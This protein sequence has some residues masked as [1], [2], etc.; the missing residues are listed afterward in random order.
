MSRKTP[1]NLTPRSAAARQS[2]GLSSL[3]RQIYKKVARQ[4]YE[5]TLMAVGEANTGKTTLLKALFEPDAEPT[6]GEMLPPPPKTVLVVPRQVSIEEHGVSFKLNIIDTPGFGDGVNNAGC[7]EQIVEYI[8]TT[9]VDYLRDE[10]SANRNELVD[11]RV[12]CLLY[13]INPSRHSLKTLDIETLKRVHRKVNVVPVI[14]KADTLTKQELSRLKAQIK[15]DLERE[16]IQIFWPGAEVIGP[17]VV[18]EVDGE[19]KRGRR[20][21]WG[22]VDIDNEVHCDFEKLRQM[23]IKTH[24]H[25]LKEQTVE[26]YERFRQEK[27]ERASK[28]QVEE[29]SPLMDVG[30]ITATDDSSVAA[31]KLQQQARR[32]G[33]EI[34]GTLKGKSD[35]PDGGGEAA[36]VPSSSA[37]TTLAEDD[38]ETAA[39]ATRALSPFAPVISRHS[40]TPNSTISLDHLETMKQ[41]VDRQT[42]LLESMQSQIVADAERLGERPGVA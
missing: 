9:F 12:H 26:H 20:Y 8:E 30:N 23:L 11:R 25:A 33:G 6:P 37:H 42:A 4:G 18:V 17:N 41:E 35:D 38:L 28:I 40:T 22:M 10:S 1:L 29:V 15:A 7:W 39:A 34:D 31:T 13:F 19:A 3:S 16:K 32:N 36:D 14:A 2:V 5:F 27:L 21:P 24:L